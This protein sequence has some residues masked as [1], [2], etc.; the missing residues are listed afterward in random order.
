M[1]GENRHC[2]ECG[3]ETYHHIRVGYLVCDECG[4]HYDLDGH[5]LLAPT[6]GD[7]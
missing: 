4:A 2:G 5:P 3:K 7:A 1:A 6:G